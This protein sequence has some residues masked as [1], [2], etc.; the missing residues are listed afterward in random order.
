MPTE[1]EERE[2]GEDHVGEEQ[3][4]KGGLRSIERTKL[5]GAGGV[6]GQ[7]RSRKRVTQQKQ[8]IARQSRQGRRG[9]DKGTK[10]ILILLLLIAT[11]ILFLLTTV[12]ATARINLTLSS[13]EL[14]PVD[15]VFVA[16]QERAQSKDISYGRRG[17]YHEVREKAVANVI[18]ERQNTRAEGKAVLRN[19]N[20]SGESLELVNRTRLQSESG[21][22]YRLVGK[23]VI[24]GGKTVNGIFVPG[25]KQVK[26]EA[27]GIGKKY[28]I[29]EKGARLSIPGLVKYKEFAD[30]HAITETGIIGGFSGERLI[31]NA[32]EEESARRQLQQ[33]IEKKL[34]DDLTQSIANNSLAERIVFEDG[35]FVEFESLESIQKDDAVM[36][37]ERGT[38]H[39]ISFR[40]T[41]LA[42]L[43]AKYAPAAAK[44]NIPPSRAETKDLSIEIEKGE[45]FDFKSSLE[46]RFRLK[47]SATLFWDIDEA[48]FLTDIAGKTRS[49][50]Q[51]IIGTEYPQIQEGLLGISIFPAWRNTLPSN[52]SKIE[53]EIQHASIR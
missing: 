48:L 30:T 42:A 53:T 10:K 39:A 29:Q 41:E 33:E 12:F 8:N 6:K 38:L 24:P 45:E 18:R 35:V 17:P 14:P 43:L 34:R 51:E 23:E 20:P 49:E 28:N 3:D 7:P 47:G 2:M 36:V 22:I 26:I 1:E 32:E 40:E 5:S 37:R 13:V 16:I 46:F 27:D 52:K 11:V 44:L 4:E 19:T 15:G 21:Q 9:K 31:P 25:E 50:A